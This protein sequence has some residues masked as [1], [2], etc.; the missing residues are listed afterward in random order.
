[1]IM[2]GFEFMAKEPFKEVYIH[3]TVRDHTGKKMS[4]S[5]GNILDPIEIIDEFGADALR[6]SVI[7]LT[8]VGQDVFLSKDKFQSG[9]NFANK[10]WNA[11]RFVINNL[12]EDVDTDLCVLYKN[13]G[14]KLADKWILSNLYTTLQNL[15]R[16]V[17]SYRFSEA[18]NLLYDFI[19]HKYCDWYVEISKI[20]IKEK[21]TQ[22]I[23]YKALE[24]SLRMLHPFM[25]FITEEIF[26]RLPHKRDSIMIQAWPHIQKDLID[27]KAERDMDFLIRLIVNVR[28]IRAEM[29]VPLDKKVSA[30]ISVSKKENADLI[31]ENEPYIKNLAKAEKLEAGIK[32]PKPK[33]SAAAV[34]SGTEIYVPLAGLIDV[35]AEKARLAKKI[36][37]S[38][39]I[40][41]GISNRLANKEFLKKA[42]GEVVE[43]EREKEKQ[44]KADVAKLK[45]NLESL[46]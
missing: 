12:S 17:D 6:F 32:L 5:L 14:L 35:A 7:S 42:P 29:S 20:S 28:N 3:G 15:N 33:Q 4:K 19:W 9:R 31:R 30:V 43:K 8:A 45:V 21:T 11:S 37:E 23:L 10:I 39:Q 46:E 44:L 22:I 38:E 18:V 16:A 13:A 41:K 1:M 24:K 27:K 2:A 25:P 26:S 34:V 36:A 40:V